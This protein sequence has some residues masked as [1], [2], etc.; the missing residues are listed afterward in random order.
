MADGG[1]PST[2]FGKNIVDAGAINGR[3]IAGLLTQW[4]FSAADTIDN[5]RFVRLVGVHRN[6]RASRCCCSGRSCAHGSGRFRPRSHGPHLQHAR[7]PGVGLVDAAVQ[8]SVR[9]A[10]RRRRVSHDGRGRRRPSPADDGPP[11]R[12]RRAARRSPVDVSARGD[13]LLGVLRRRADRG[14]ARNRVRAGRLVKAHFG[15]AAVVARRSRT[16]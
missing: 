9:C 4:F 11:G 1:W 6:H 13:V 10:R 14:G 12:R 16:S 8:R 15:L 3:P 5:L 7:L 2:Q